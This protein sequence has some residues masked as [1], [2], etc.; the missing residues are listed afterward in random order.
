MNPVIG[1]AL[2][3]GGVN[4]LGNLLGWKSNKDTNSSNYAIAQMN[5]AYNE[6]MLQKEM[7]YNTRMW[8]MQNEYNTPAAQRKRYEAAGINPYMALG[9]IQAGQAG[10]AGGVKTPSAQPVTM[11]P[12]Q[13]DFGGIGQAAQNY[14]ANRL[15]EKRNDAAIAVDDEKASQLRIENQYKAAELITQIMERIEKTH[16]TKSKRIYQQ[17]MNNYADEMFGSDIKVKQRQAESIEADIKS[18][19]VDTALKELQ[20]AGFPQQFQLQLAAMSADI[21][22]KSAQAKM[23]KQQ[24]IHEVQK[25]FKTFAETRGIKLNNRIL[26]RSADSIVN[27]AHT[28]Q[29]HSN[30]F[31]A[32][33]EYLGTN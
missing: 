7:D 6:R 32:L 29:W 20:L 21:L 31:R 4:L 16:D 12:F 28:E 25:M 5:N 27:K 33:M 26:E 9:N 13:P 14:F 1:S 17:I 15:A 22:L 23:T 8:R 19:N 2:I 11:Q 3:G 30:P 10:S 18:K 24:T